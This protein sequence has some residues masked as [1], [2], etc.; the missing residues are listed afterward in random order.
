MTFQVLPNSFILWPQA[1]KSK[2]EKGYMKLRCAF[3][4]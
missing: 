3:L 1:W 4:L 2:E